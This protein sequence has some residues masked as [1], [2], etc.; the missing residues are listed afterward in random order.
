MPA[1]GVILS[2]VVPVYNESDNILPFYK[3]LTG[4]LEGLGESF[5]IL[6]VDDGSTDLTPDRL[7]ALSGSDN[8][9]RVIGLSRNFGKEIALT[10]GI[11]HASGEAVI[12]IDVDLQD[13]PELIPRLVEKWREGYEVVYATRSERLGESWLKKWTAALFYK[14]IKRFT[15]FEVPADT[16]D[17][18]IM[19]RKVVDALKE[20]REHHRFMKG[21][22][23][24]VGFRQ[25]G[26]FYTRD[27]RYT[28][29]TKWNY[30]KLTNLAIEGI[31][32]FSYVPLQLA[33]W[34]GFIVSFMAFLFGCYMVVR[35]LLYGDPVRGYPSM[36][37]IILFLGGVQLFSL[38]VMGE[39][40]GRIYMESKKRPLY[41]VRDRLGF[42]DRNDQ[43]RRD[44]LK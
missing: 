43:P 33:T 19:D 4:V 22:F 11:D 29:K 8:R 41:V 15:D 37:V 17:F 30:R 35:T 39:Y 42:H 1:P 18:R 44:L 20:V 23:S 26:I 13:P 25:T 28:G 5:E 21:L 32:S 31:T 16:G 12:P 36:I 3:R 2:I 7:T 9:I 40:V 24:W 27:A 10:A 6:F 38:G 34:C 14:F